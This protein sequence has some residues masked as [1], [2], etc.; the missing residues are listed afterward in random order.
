MLRVSLS[1]R[2]QG[3]KEA[4]FRAQTLPGSRVPSVCTGSLYL[5]DTAATCRS[6][7]SREP[8]RS[9]LHRERA[10]FSLKVEG[11]A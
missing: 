10:L 3:G 5:I 11:G 9:S 2:E 6:A 4:R 7:V 8:G 1:L